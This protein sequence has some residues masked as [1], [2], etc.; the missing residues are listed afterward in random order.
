MAELQFRPLRPEEDTDLFALIDAN[1]PR[2]RKFWWE[3]TTQTPA[4][5][6]Q[7]INTVNELEASNGAP[8]RGIYERD[9]LIGVCALHTIDYDAKRSLFGFWLDEQAAG[10]GHGHEIVQELVRLAFDEL[11]LNEV[12]IVTNEQNAATR[13]LAE[14]S[15][16]RLVEVS[17]RPEWE[18]VGNDPVTMAVYALSRS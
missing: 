4:D 7:F 10:K 5:S 15:G 18:V 16:F 6:R 17:D 3:S 12:R 11:N 13:A 8:T 14:G 1:R 2:L 9:R